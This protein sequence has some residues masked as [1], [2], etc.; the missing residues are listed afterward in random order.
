MRIGG[1]NSPIVGCMS[2]PSVVLPSISAT[3]TPL[4]LTTATASVSV[5]SKPP[6]ESSGGV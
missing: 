3:T 6:N 1:T 2:L 4:A 5:T